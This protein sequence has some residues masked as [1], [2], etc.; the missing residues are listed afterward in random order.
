[1][2]SSSLTSATSIVFLL[3]FLLDVLG[4]GIVEVALLVEA[5][6]PALDQSVGIRCVRSAD[7]TLVLLL[8]LLLL[9]TVV[10]G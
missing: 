3:D 2:M 8:V 5:K 6:D 4:L 9:D 10:R 1:M 7:L